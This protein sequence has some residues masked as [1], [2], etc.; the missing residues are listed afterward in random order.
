[1]VQPSM[2][3][4]AVTMPKPALRVVLSSVNSAMLPLICASL[5]PVVVRFLSSEVAYTCMMTTMPISPM[6]TAA[7]ISGRLMPRMKCGL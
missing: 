6:S 2:L 3:L 4:V 5:V 1:M 7:R